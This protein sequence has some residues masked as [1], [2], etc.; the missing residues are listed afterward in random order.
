MKKEDCIAAVQT[1]FPAFSGRLYTACRR[2]PETGVTLCS[3]ARELAGMKK[4]ENRVKGIHWSIRVN[5][6]QDALLKRRMDKLHYTS[7]QAYIESLLTKEAEKQLREERKEKDRAYTKEQDPF[8]R[9]KQV[10]DAAKR[11]GASKR[12]IEEFIKTGRKRREAKR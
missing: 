6:E 8:Y 3:R 7:K 10:K 11:N 9:E 2:T 5:A 4:P 1:E 12:D